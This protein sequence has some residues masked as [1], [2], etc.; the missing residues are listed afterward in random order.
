MREKPPDYK[1]GDRVR[2]EPR[3]EPDNKERNG[4]MGTVM[5]V[6]FII[7]DAAYRTSFRPD[8]EPRDVWIKSGYLRRIDEEEKATS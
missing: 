1:I 3:Y 8:G 6:R 2:Y 7:K 4:R 5:K